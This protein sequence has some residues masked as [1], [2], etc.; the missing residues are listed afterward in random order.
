MRFSPRRTPQVGQPCGLSE[1]QIAA[2]MATMRAFYNGYCFVG[3]E[4]APLYNPTLALYFL[5]HLLREC[6]YPEQMLDHNL[7]TDRNRIDYVVRLPHGE[8]LVGAALHTNAPIRV[9]RLADRF[10]ID[11]MLTPPSDH[12]FLASL[13]YYFGVLTVAGRNP[14]G[15]IELVIPIW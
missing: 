5:G 15:E 6:R 11:D 13:L 4:Q 2:A 7:A 1:T 14:F 3:S 8:R 12:G 9:S 10:G